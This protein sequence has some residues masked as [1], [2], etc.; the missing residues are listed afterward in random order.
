M[1][2]TLQKRQQARSSLPKPTASTIRRVLIVRMRLVVLVLIVI[3]FLK[4]LPRRRVQHPQQTEIE[5]RQVEQELLERLVLQKSRDISFDSRQNNSP[6]PA[7][8]F[9]RVG[10]VVVDRCDGVDEIIVVFDRSHLVVNG[11]AFAEDLLGESTEFWDVV[12]VCD[13]VDVDVVGT[14]AGVFGASLRAAESEV[15]EIVD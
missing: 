1:R 12:F 7:T 4:R 14:G 3:D 5:P 6:Q 11:V 13:G 10:S 2:Q 9:D 8:A 15:V